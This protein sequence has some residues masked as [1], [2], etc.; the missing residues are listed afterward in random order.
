MNQ[1]RIVVSGGPGTGKTSVILALEASGFFCFHEIIRSM[2]LKAKEEGDTSS[3]ASNPI[4]SVSDPLRFNQ[5]ILDGRRDHFLKATE[6]KEPFVF[7][8]RGL[9]DVLAYMDFFDQSYE[10]NFVTVC[11]EH[12]YDKVFLLPPWEE[13]YVSDNERFESYEE[14]ILIH[15]CLVST[16]LRFGY[17]PLIVPKGSVKE[18]V[19]FVLQQIKSG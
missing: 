10:K 16:Y 9:P 18:R 11:E 15:D 4:A 13:I 3:F 7:Y 5:R 19:T 2:T 8:D 17:S 6:V 1:E 14:A 12:T